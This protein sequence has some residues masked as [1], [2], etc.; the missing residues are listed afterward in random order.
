LNE[1]VEGEIRH[2]KNVVEAARA[3][4]AE[5]TRDAIPNTNPS[6]GVNRLRK[7]LNEMGYQLKDSTRAPGLF[8]ENAESGEQ[9]RIME[10]PN[11]QFRSDPPQKH[12]NDYYYR[13]RP[14]RNV[15]YGS[16]I[17]IPDKD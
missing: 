7:E 15:P 3:R 8:Y 5:I 4:L 2:F 14:S 9:V 12:Y 16:H 13:Y 17:T 1:T 6:W 11:Q 10:R